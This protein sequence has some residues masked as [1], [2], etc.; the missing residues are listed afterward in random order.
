MQAG[1]LK[2]SRDPVDIRELLIHCEEI[3]AL[4]LEEKNITLENSH[5]SH[6]LVTGDADLWKMYSVISWT[7]P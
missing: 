4:R 6:V 5:D 1:Q 2:M 3:F 7:M